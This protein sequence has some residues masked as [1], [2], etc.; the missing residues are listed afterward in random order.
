MKC[1]INFF[2]RIGIFRH[3]RAICSSI[4]STYWNTSFAKSCFF[5]DPESSWDAM[6]KSY[7]TLEIKAIMSLLG[8][9]LRELGSI[10]FENETAR[11]RNI[12]IISYK[13]SRLRMSFIPLI[14]SW[15]RV[16]VFILGE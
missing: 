16:Y 6:N 14:I 12:M 8:I 4:S 13:Y 5:S 7:S 9:F 1:P 11:S 10:D 2:S 3:Y 15:I